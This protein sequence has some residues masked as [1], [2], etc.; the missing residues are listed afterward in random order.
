LQ[1]AKKLGFLGPGPVEVHIE[2]AAAFAAA[3]GPGFAG[4]AVDLGSGGGLPGLPL[5]LAWPGSRWL[6]VDRADRRTAFLDDAVRELGLGDRVQVRRDSAEAVA[7]DPQVRGQQQLVVARSFGP[8]AVVAEC[9]AP[10][11]A[12]GGLLV[13]SEPP[14]EGGS[15]WPAHGLAELGLHTRTPAEGSKAGGVAVMEADGTCP[16]GYPRRPGTPARRPLW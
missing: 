1:R 2:H 11:L 15:R 10:M 14:V 13:V 3:V 16:A 5:A 7:R 4:A 12:S 9:G 8:P 6:L